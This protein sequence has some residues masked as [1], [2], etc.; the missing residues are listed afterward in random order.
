[1]HQPIP[2]R[3]TS[4]RIRHIAT[5]FAAITAATV[6]L[7]AL[8]PGQA[9]ANFYDN[10]DHEYQGLVKPSEFHYIGFDF[11][12]KKGEPNTGK[13]RK[14]GVV[15]PTVCDF[16]GRITVMPVG[17]YVKSPVKVTNGKFHVKNKKV[18]VKDVNGSLL[19]AR[20][21]MKGTL[22]G[23]NAKGTYQFTFDVQRGCKFGVLKW[24]AR[25]GRK[26]TIPL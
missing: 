8:G 15:T 2:T 16:N 24:K 5:T 21:T 19:N 4:T 12:K 22:K 3:R 1:M 26:V 18:K 23:K 11:V 6:L 10:Y 7:A 17:V 9:N 14:L 13:I 25:K 20:L